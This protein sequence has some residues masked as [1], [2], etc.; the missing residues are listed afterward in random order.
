VHA[1]NAKAFRT[2]Q[3]GKLQAFGKISSWI[4]SFRLLISRDNDLVSSPNDTLNMNFR[5][6]NGEAIL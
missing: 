5:S 3:I 1:Q 4:V 2:N 6:Y